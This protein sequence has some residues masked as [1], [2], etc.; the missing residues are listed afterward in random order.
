M[1]DYT[2]YKHDLGTYRV[3]KSRWGTYKSVLEDGTDMVTGATEEAVR[4]VTEH[5]HMPWH[6]GSDTS[7]IKVTTHDDIQTDELK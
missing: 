1:T 4:V 6:Y 7:D 3:E 5:I 2:W